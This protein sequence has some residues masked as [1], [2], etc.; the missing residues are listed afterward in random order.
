MLT[1][2]MI[3]CAV[4]ASEDMDMTNDAA[5]GGGGL[6]DA[7]ETECE[8]IELDKLG[9]DYRRITKRIEDSREERG[10]QGQL[11]KNTPG[12]LE[13][14]KIEE[15]S[16][17]KLRG[18]FEAAQTNLA[19]KRGGFWGFSKGANVKE[20]FH[21]TSRTDPSVIFRTSN[22]FKK[23]EGKGKSG[24]YGAGVYF[25]EDFCYSHR[26]THHI[27]PDPER[28]RCRYGARYGHTKEAHCQRERRHRDTK[29]REVSCW[30]KWMKKSM[31]LCDVAVGRSWKS[32]WGSKRDWSLF[33]NLSLPATSHF[34]KPPSK[35]FGRECDSVRSTRDG[36][37]VFVPSRDGWRMY[38]VYEP[39]R[40]YPKYLITYA[41]EY[42]S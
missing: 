16:N 20:L 9:D 21:G 27:G 35:F 25:A 10:T 14:L 32:T 28:T 12:K 38:V 34:T 6:R 31:L 11:Y 2:L 41:C 30:T 26:Y 19:A 18:Q 7:Q 33:C 40:I 39:K 24:Y 3:T 17:K 8:L 4:M 36:S 29:H 22:G 42:L 13:I 15:I 5:Q 37:S 23:P 1:A